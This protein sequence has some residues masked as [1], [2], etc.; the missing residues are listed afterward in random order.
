MIVMAASRWQ[1]AAK[2]SLLL[3]GSHSTLKIFAFTFNLCP[4]R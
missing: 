3:L 1:G 4:D 2:R